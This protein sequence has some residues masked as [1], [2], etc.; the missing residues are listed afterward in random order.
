MCI[1]LHGRWSSQGLR[2]MSWRYVEHFFRIYHIRADSLASEWISRYCNHS[3][4][5]RLQPAP[6]EECSAEQGDVLPVFQVTDGGSLQTAVALWKESL[7]IGRRGN[8]RSRSSCCIMYT[9]IDRSE[10]PVVYA[11]SHPVRSCLPIAQLLSHMAGVC[12]RLWARLTAGLCCAGVLI[13]SAYIRVKSEDR[14]SHDP[15]TE[16]T[17]QD[18]TTQRDLITSESGQQHAPIPSVEA[19]TAH[20]SW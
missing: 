8:S 15:T 4:H 2:R 20:E 18:T 13:R 12:D 9:I 19:V 7:P 17:M 14:G 1:A 6:R 16:L 5:R 3:K 11:L 10:T